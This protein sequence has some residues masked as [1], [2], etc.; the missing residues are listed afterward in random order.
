MA[1]QMTTTA[2]M[3]HARPGRAGLDYETGRRATSRYCISGFD[4]HNEEGKAYCGAQDKLKTGRCRGKEIGYLG[5]K[6]DVLYYQ[7]LGSLSAIPLATLLVPS[8]IDGLW[9]Y[10]LFPVAGTLVFLLGGTLFAGLVDPLISP[11]I[12]ANGG[13]VQLVT[14]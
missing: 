8:S 10:V 3:K 12:I 6:V 7:T 13:P 14:F 1:K 9:F 11:M 4:A 5:G 2:R